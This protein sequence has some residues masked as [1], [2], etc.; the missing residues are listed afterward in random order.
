MIS[1]YAVNHAKDGDPVSLEIAEK[2]LELIIAN[3]LKDLIVGSGIENHR[4]IGYPHKRPRLEFTR[5]FFSSVTAHQLLAEIHELYEGPS[6]RLKEAEREFKESL[7]NKQDKTLLRL[8]EQYHPLNI[9]ARERYA[10]A[11]EYMAEIW[12][13]PFGKFKKLVEYKSKSP[14]RVQL[15]NFLAVLT[16]D[17]IH[18]VLRDV[19]EVEKMLNRGKRDEA[20]DAICGAY[21]EWY[22]KTN[23]PVYYSCMGSHFGFCVARL[24]P[25]QD[26]EK[27]VLRLLRK[28]EIVCQVVEY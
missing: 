5:P 24:L 4:V 6:N 3:D 27:K 22:L 21:S 7:R 18:S 25:H 2:T 1:I 9:K 10:R 19:D 23:E 8:F 20:I 17:S 11:V 12:G 26:K 13:K 14:Q 15:L 16:D 28:R